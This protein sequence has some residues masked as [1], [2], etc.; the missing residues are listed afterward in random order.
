MSQKWGSSNQEYE[1]GG[2]DAS[3]WQ[4]TFVLAKLRGDS[5]PGYFC[6]FFLIIYDLV[7]LVLLVF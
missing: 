6:G 3:I 4:S 2:S 1:L 5:F 7:L